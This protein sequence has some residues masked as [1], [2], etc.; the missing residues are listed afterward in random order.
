LSYNIETVIVIKF[1]EVVKQLVQVNLDNQIGVYSYE[2]YYN[3]DTATKQVSIGI[4]FFPFMYTNVVL[5]L[6]QNREFQCS[7]FINL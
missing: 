3:Y 4:Y 1:Y 7:M 6:F 5:N 2:V